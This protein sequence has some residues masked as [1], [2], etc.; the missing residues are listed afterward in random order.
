MTTGACDERDGVGDDGVPGVRVF[1]EDG[2][3]AVSDDR[4][5]FHFEAVRRGL[6]V[7]QLDVASLPAGGGGGLLHAERPLRGARVLAAGRRAGQHALA[8][9][10]PRP[11]AGRRCRRRTR[12]RSR[13]RTRRRVAGRSGRF[14]ACGRRGSAGRP[15]GWT[16]GRRRDG[17]GRARRAAAPRRRAAAAAAVVRDSARA[18]VDRASHRWSI[19]SRPVTARRCGASARRSRARG[20][21]SRSR[22]RSRTRRGRA[23]STGRPPRPGD[24]RREARV[25]ARGPPRRTGGGR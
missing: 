17:R 6:H 14:A 18:G 22:S 3:F 25:R 19:G 21:S 16:G 12:R 20:S 1:L 7:V 11:Q 4:G 24:R 5:M 8:R 23:R 13:R 10:L 15:R 9:R 2:T